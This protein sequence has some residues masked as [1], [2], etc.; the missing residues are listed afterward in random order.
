MKPH[1]SSPINNDNAQRCRLGTPPGSA[2]CRSSHRYSMPHQ[3]SRCHIHRH[4]NRLPC[5]PRLCSIPWHPRSRS[6]GGQSTPSTH[7][8]T[9]S[10]TRMHSNHHFPSGNFP[11]KHSRN[12]RRASPP[13]KVDDC[14]MRNPL[15]S[16]RPARSTSQW[17]SIPTRTSSSSWRE[18]AGDPQWLWIPDRLLIKGIPVHPTVIRSRLRPPGT[19]STLPTAV[20]HPQSRPAA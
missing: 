12:L 10:S 17:S 7:W 4:S 3:R 11:R 5:K 6:T 20:P 16:A 15:R 18:L 14:Q 19:G 2:T 9:L 8:H 13:E 1:R